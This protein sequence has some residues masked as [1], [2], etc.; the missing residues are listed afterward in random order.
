[1]HR[2]LKY[3]IFFGF[4]ALG[5][6]FG[7]IFSLTRISGLS[8]G[9]ALVLGMVAVI[10][11]A[12]LTNRAVSHPLQQVA[13]AALGIAGGD[14]ERRIVVLGSDPAGTLA[15][16]LNQLAGSLRHSLED[17]TAERNRMQAILN[18]MGD[19]MIALDGQGNVLALNPVMEKVFGISESA[20]KGRPLLQAVRDYELERMWRDVLRTGKSAEQELRLLTPEPRTFNVHF[21]PL[22]GAEHGV[23]ALLRDVTEKRRLERLRTEFIA[24][25]SHELRTPLT[26]IRGFVET[27][28]DGAVENPQ[29]AHRFLEILDHEVDRLSHLVE[30][31]LSL[32][33]IEEQRCQFHR[34]P[35]DLGDLVRRAAEAFSERAAAKGL[36]LAVDVDDSLPPVAGDAG[37][38]TQVFD[39]LIANALKFTDR[40]SIQLTARHEN[41][42]VSVE[43]RDTGIGVPEDALPRLFER[44]YRVDRSRAAGRGGTGLGLAIVKHIMEGHGGGVS[45]SSKVGKGTSFIVRIPAMPF[46][47]EFNDILTL[48]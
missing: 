30:D 17:V 23:V 25:V 9:A 31:M 42:R 33:R 21:A 20:V 40:G 44:F 35:V 36:D 1:M 12:Y 34:S 19:G 37:L 6:S 43:V 28:Q 7:G 46:S 18:S 32:G 47:S 29:T 14:L 15:E 13:E 39:N 27:L 5:V 26:S 11:A 16:S 48:H 2:P 38:L 41:D 10:V 24:N 8:D 4:I 22:K 45:V 3:K